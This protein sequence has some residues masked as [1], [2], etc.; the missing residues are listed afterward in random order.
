MSDLTVLIIDEHGETSDLLAAR[1]ERIAGIRVVGCTANAA[2]GAELAHELKPDVILADFRRLGP[3]RAETYRWLAEMS[4]T[5]RMVA[6][7]TYLSEGEEDA[8]R[9][10]GVSACLLK[11]IAVRDLAD[12]LLGLAAR[13]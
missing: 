11:G 10:A 8:F 13:V 6:L 1:L 9:Q 5:S 4:P 7:T 3:P 2:L 12:E